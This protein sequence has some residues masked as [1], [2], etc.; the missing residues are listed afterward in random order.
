MQTAIPLQHP[1]SNR[2]IPY[3]TR[4]MRKRVIAYI[5][6]QSYRLHSVDGLEASG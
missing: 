6:I 4:R 3:T 5:I 1:R 2:P